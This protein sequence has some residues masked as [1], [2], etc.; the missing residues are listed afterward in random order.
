MLLAM[1]MHKIVVILEWWVM[2]YGVLQRA[3][4]WLSTFPQEN[5]SPLILVHG[6]INDYVAD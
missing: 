2:R 5:V 6:I 3:Q 4:I 1:Y